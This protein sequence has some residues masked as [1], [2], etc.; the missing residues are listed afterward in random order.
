MEFF[1]NY[2]ENIEFFSKLLRKHRIFSK[3]LKNFEFT[4][5]KKHEII[6]KLL[7][8]LRIFS[9]L[10]I[11]TKSPLPPRRVRDATTHHQQRIPGFGMSKTY[12]LNIGF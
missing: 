1:R 9:K 5:N 3:L 6:S 4:K 7:R 11:I 2:S 10:Q 12:V 8:K